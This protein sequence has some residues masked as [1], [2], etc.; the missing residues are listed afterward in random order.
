M[1]QPSRAGDLYPEVVKELVATE[2]A[3]RESLESRALGVIGVSGTLVTLLI[4]IAAFARGKDTP[5]HGDARGL[6][7]LSAVLFLASAAAAIGASAPRRVATID[8]P[9]LKDLLRE[10]WDAT[11]DSARQREVAEHLEQLKELQGINDSKGGFLL[12][13]VVVQVL[14]TLAATAA[15]AVTL[16]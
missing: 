8:V 3:R 5:V 11:P 6:L 16:R 1:T 12:A 14:A 10:T 15:V 7:L 13:S 9:A 4:G 2:D